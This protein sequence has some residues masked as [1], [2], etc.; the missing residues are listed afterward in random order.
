MIDL[1]DLFIPRRL[2]GDRVLHRDRRAESRDA[3]RAFY[4]HAVPEKRCLADRAFDN[5]F[6]I[7]D[8]STDLFGLQAVIAPVQRVP[9]AAVPIGRASRAQAAGVQQPAGEGVHKLGFI[10]RDRRRTVIAVLRHPTHVDALVAALADVQ[11]R[12]RE[13]VQLQ[14]A[15]RFDLNDLGAFRSALAD[16]HSSQRD[17]LGGVADIAFSDDVLRKNTSFFSFWQHCKER[18][19][20]KI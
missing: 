13:N 5:D 17:Q 16:R 15:R 10:G 20:E 2:V 4:L 6:V 1:H 18:K 7:C 14:T 11:P 19:K 9:L 8:L 12:V 3:N